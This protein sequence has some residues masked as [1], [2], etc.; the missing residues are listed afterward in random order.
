MLA[1]SLENIKKYQNEIPCNSKNINSIYSKFYIMINIFKKS[2]CANHTLK[3]AIF[4]EV[5]I[6]L[7]TKEEVKN[8][9]LTI[10][11]LGLYPLQVSL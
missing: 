7:K 4:E 1:K 2:M 5:L 10:K 3:V 9:G 11:E 6:A 8:F